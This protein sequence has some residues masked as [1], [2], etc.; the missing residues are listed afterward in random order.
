MKLGRDLAEFGKNATDHDF[1]PP[2]L[3]AANKKGR[4][5]QSSPS[6]LKDK[7]IWPAKIIVDPKLFNIK[8]I[9]KKNFKMMTTF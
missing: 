3:W 4:V 5:L 9:A 6:L 1:P 8:I 2:L 7:L